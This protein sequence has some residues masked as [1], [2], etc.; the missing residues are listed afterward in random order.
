MRLCCCVD[1]YY[2]RGCMNECGAGFVG[3]LWANALLGNGEY[4]WNEKIW[5]R[6]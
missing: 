1:M 6:E 5:R 4:V 3:D 2:W